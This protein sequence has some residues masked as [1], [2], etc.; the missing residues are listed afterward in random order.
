MNDHQIAQW[1]LDLTA[2]PC[3]KYKRKVGFDFEDEQE[4][5]EEEYKTLL[6][7]GKE[8]FKQLY[9]YIKGSLKDSAN[10]HPRN[11]LALF[12]CLLRLNL[13]QP[14]LGIMFGI[15][16]VSTVSDTINSVSK[17]LEKIFVPKFLG[18]QH[19]SR[20]QAIAEH[21]RKLFKTLFETPD[22]TLFPIFDGTYLYI[23]KPS[24]FQLQKMT[25]S[26]QKKRNLVK[27]MM[28][29]LE[30]GYVIDAPG[31]YYNNG[32]NNDAGILNSLLV[33]GGELLRFLDPSKDQPIFDRGF[34]DN[35]RPLKMKGFRIHMPELKAK[36]KDQF[37]TAQGNI[38]RKCTL[39][40]WLVEAVNGRLKMKYKFFADVIPGSYLPKL[41][42]FFRI[43]VALINCFSPPLMEDTE[44]NHQIAM[45]ALVRS[46]IENAMKKRVVSEKLDRNTDDWE[47]ASSEV[48]QNFP[49]LSVQDLENLT[50]GVYQLSLA[51]EYT[52]KHLSEESEFQI[53]LNDKTPGVL[54][55]KLDSRFKSGKRHQLWIEF[56]P[57]LQ[58]HHTITGYYCT[59]W[60][61]NAGNMV[62]GIQTSS[63]RELEAKKTQDSRVFRC[64]ASVTGGK[65][66]SY[67]R[68]IIIHSPRSTRSFV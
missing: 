58:D 54:R 20:D 29:V 43:A 51:K 45:E 32:A 68:S 66:S 31:P 26:E 48:L 38:S 2:K 42:R 5:T 1:I 16:Q 24:D 49:V 33:E 19:M 12:L 14:V 4:H 15:Q 67:S 52:K 27:P 11:A 6:G 35:V 36:A 55:A 3:Q 63:A 53:Q 44:R 65:L 60:Q 50:L 25:W 18:F 39:V 57:T 13:S 10:R 9:Q 17:A 37:T 64:S 41:T 46:K 56:N 61:G 34:R 28:I 21:G 40:R 7:L 8:D 30:D 62:Y 22:D 59:C 47:T 23:D